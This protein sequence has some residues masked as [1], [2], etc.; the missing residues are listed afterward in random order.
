VLGELARRQHGVV[1]RR[2][3]L[4]LGYSP[5]A[6]GRAARDGRIHPLHRGAYAVGHL[7]VSD[8][9]ACLAAVM[10]CG[11]GAMLSHS[12]AA[13]LWGLQAWCPTPAH[14][15]IPSRGHQN[16]GIVI[17]HSTILE[18]VDEAVVEG[19]P[20]TAIP[21]TLLDLAGLGRS[22][23]LTSAIDQAERRD[24]L[25][26]AAVDELLERSGRHPGRRNL[27]TALGIYREPV[28]SRARSERLFLA[29]VK[30]AGLPRPSLNA[31]VAGHEVD[32]YWE[33]ERFAVEVDGWGPHRTRKAFEEDP[34]RIEELKLADIDSIRITAR[35]IEREPKT[36]AARLR[37]LLEM[38]RNELRRRS[39]RS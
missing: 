1:G 28:F 11:S 24:L 3:L 4:G 39:G 33:K 26:L 35:R 19:I 18:P 10:A 23:Q 8:H 38:R 30:K 31:F 12:S 5:A 36:V 37:R 29:L 21:R 14:V 27:R 25:A 6:V 20:A 22:R 13:W 17:H 2:Q 16:A 34:V 7:A 32:A 15:T 9:G